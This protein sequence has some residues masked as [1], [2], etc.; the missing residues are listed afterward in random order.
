MWSIG[1]VMKKITKM[2]TGSI[3]LAVVALGSLF[4]SGM[5]TTK[6]RFTSKLDR[7]SEA[8]LSDFSGTV[9]SD[10]TSM[11]GFLEYK[12]VDYTIN[13]L[14]NVEGRIKKA[15]VE[16]SDLPNIT[17][18]GLSDSDAAYCSEIYFSG[19]KTSYEIFYYLKT[20]EISNYRGLLNLYMSCYSLKP[21]TQISV[22]DECTNFFCNRLDEFSE[23]SEPQDLCESVFQAIVYTECEPSKSKLAD[24]SKLSPKN[25]EEL[26]CFYSAFEY[27]RA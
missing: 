19:E 5:L 12:G 14:D 7:Y 27:W 6:G 2:F 23:S 8:Y 9:D 22:N 3:L 10:K 20:S 11:A 1:V 17:C 21:D 16:G 18:S 24:I 25:L 15:L 13:W 26:S 4:L